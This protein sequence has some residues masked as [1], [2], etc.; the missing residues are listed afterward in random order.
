[1]GHKLMPKDEPRVLT[2]KEESLDYTEGSLDTFNQISVAL[3]K[4]LRHPE[5]SW[6]EKSLLLLCLFD[7][8]YYSLNKLAKMS[9]D[10][11]GCPRSAFRSLAQKGWMERKPRIVKIDNQGNVAQIW[12][13]ILGQKTKNLLF[14]SD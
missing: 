13:N 4:V 12:E 2:E 7:H 11:K 6:R 10:G 5:L 1:M 3:K 9:T 14:C 8:E